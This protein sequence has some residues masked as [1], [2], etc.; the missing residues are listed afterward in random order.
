MSTLDKTVFVD[1]QFLN[2]SIAG[3]S[4]H[5]KRLQSK[6]FYDKTGDRIFQQIMEMPEYYL[7]RAEMDIMKT[8]S[9]QIADVLELDGSPF[10]LFELG[11][12]DASKS[13]HLLKTL[14][15]RDIAFTYYPI[16]I[17]ANV[18][19]GLNSSLPRL[20][21]K[22]DFQGLEGDYF[23]M[24]KEVTDRSKRRKVVLFMG[25]NI[26]NMHP[27]EAVAFCQS[28]SK[29]FSG[30]DRLIIG[31]DLKK[32]PDQ[33]LKAYNDASGITRDFNLNLLRRM[34]RELGADFEVNAFEHY[35]SYNPE[36][37]ACKSYLIS[38]HEQRVLIG[39]TLITFEQNEYILMEISQKYSLE[40]ISR[41]ALNSG[42]V[43]EKYFSDS[44]GYFVDALWKLT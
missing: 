27:E 21:P 4:Q 25:A 18:I 5:P 3:L 38:L 1:S 24:L 10:D 34:N 40:D 19:A 9:A 15:E 14:L 8:Q 26:G 2:D 22:L 28:L 11:A 37:G 42:F 32:N 16:D 31:F 23:A 20:L 39:D 43:A 7:T 12:G 33:V 17:S 41:L 29:T 44:Q 36:S 30:Q 6:Y 35:A 13:V